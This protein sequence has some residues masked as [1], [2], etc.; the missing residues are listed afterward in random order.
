MTEQYY[1][2]KTCHVRRSDG[3]QSAYVGSANL[4]GNGA[5]LHVEAG[6]ALDSAEG[7]P[8]DVLSDIAAVVDRG[9][10]RLGQGCPS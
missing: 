3:S 4:T 5:V 2:P 1:H 7:D 8:E 9:L 6:I 10:R